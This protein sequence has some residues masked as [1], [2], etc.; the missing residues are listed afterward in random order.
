[1]DGLTST[2]AERWLA[3]LSFALAGLAIVI[4][5]AFA[6]LKSLAMVAAGLGAAVESIVISTPV[7]C[8]VSAGALRVW[9]PRD[10]PGVPAPKPPRDWARLRYLAGIR[11]LSRGRRIDRR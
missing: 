3:R 7:T 1:M 4:L 6:G 2:P 11:K 9:V 8:T 10:R 5:L